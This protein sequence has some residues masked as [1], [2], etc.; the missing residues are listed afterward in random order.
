MSS[1]RGFTIVETVVAVLVAALI[2]LSIGGLSE[3]LVHRR[4]TRD[5]NSTGL[6]LAKRKT[7]GSCPAAPLSARART[8][9]PTSAGPYTA[10]WTVAKSLYE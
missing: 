1:S 6:A 2:I 9:R 8:D 7:G 5:S 10:T 3:R 4:T